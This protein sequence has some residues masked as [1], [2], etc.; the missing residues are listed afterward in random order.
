MRRY[1]RMARRVG[2]F[3]VGGLVVSQ[4]V[5]SWVG[6][7]QISP[8]SGSSSR[9]W[10]VSLPSIMNVAELFRQEESAAQSG[11]LFGDFS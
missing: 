9:T 4:S 10:A 3:E 1:R 8:P 6:L 2:A 7:M 11:G 5:L